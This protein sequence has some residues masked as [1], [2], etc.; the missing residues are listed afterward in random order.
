MAGTID[1]QQG[2]EKRRLRTAIARSRRRIDRRLR[3]SGKATG[4]LTSW[5]T[6]VERW[7][8]VGLAAGLGLG[9]I[10]AAG[11]RPRFLVGLFGARLMREMSGRTTDLLVGELKRFWSDTASQDGG[12]EA[13]GGDDG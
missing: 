2:A 8:G 3:N 11:L 7:P 10:L 5:K 6:Y 1:R 12:A 4:R 13:E 9:W